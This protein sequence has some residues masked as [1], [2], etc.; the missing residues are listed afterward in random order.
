M[1]KLQMRDVKTG[2]IEAS[3]I[4][5]CQIKYGSRTNALKMTILEGS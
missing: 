1:E 3:Q 4:N 2:W 5:C